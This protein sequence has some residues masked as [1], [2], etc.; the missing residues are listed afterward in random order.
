MNPSKPRLTLGPSIW[1]EAY[2][3][4]PREATPAT[5]DRA[6][7]MASFIWQKH[8]AEGC[9]L[10]ALGAR[11][12]ALTVAEFTEAVDTALAWGLLRIDGA[13]RLW[14]N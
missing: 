9:T 12:P 6:Q 10:A 11:W 5:R 7:I 8:H 3:R 14:A 4:Y 2:P 1:D 13:G